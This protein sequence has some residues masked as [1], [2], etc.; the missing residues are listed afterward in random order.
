MKAIVIYDSKFGNTERLAREIG[1]ALEDDYSVEVRSC[2]EPLDSVAGLD[3]L[4]VGG[5]T[6]GHGLSQPMRTFLTRIREVGLYNIPLLTFDTRFRMAA[7]L[8]GRAAPKIARE[9]RRKGAHLLAPP[10][11]FF[12]ERSDGNP[13]EPGEEQRAHEWV[14]QC[15]AAVATPA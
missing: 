2:D 6:H 11:S 14:K 15:V 9:L 10:E 12:V 3:L 1:A 8:T 7:L 5:P 13:L 4:V